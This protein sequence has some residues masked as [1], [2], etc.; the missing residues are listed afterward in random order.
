M[1]PF[2][3]V[4]GAYNV[5]QGKHLATIGVVVAGY[6]HLWV[7]R[8]LVTDGAVRELIPIIEVVAVPIVPAVVACVRHA[9]PPPFVVAG[10]YP[11]RRRLSTG[12]LGLAHVHV[13]LG[14]DLRMLLLWP[15][16]QTF[17]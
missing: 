16:P 3:L 2:V 17:P 8:A 5:H 10:A 1:S 13:L 14:V 6:D 7:V 11:R 15:Y 4:L 9:R 12:P